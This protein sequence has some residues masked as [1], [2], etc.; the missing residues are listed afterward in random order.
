MLHF[1]IDLHMIGLPCRVETWD[2]Y[3]QHSSSFLTLFPAT[4]QKS[5]RTFHAS[6][7]PFLC[8]R[9]AILWLWCSHLYLLGLQSASSYTIIWRKLQGSS[10]WFQS[11]N[12]FILPY[13]Y[14]RSSFSSLG[15]KKRCLLSVRSKAYEGSHGMPSVRPPLPW[16]QKGVVVEYVK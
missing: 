6:A 3:C 10:M 15:N 14:S 11:A 1:K 4:K 8:F 2:L 16:K 12:P 7:V 9:E 5:K 13:Q